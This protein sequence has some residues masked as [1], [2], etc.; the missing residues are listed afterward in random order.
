M[1][2]Q[3]EKKKCTQ[4]DENVDENSSV[5][6]FCLFAASSELFALKHKIGAHLVELELE[7]CIVGIFCTVDREL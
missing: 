3:L 4:F 2:I 6:Y 1:H 7:G 5:V